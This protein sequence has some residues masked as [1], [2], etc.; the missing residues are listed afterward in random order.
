MKLKLD[1]ERMSDDFFEDTRILGIACPLKNYQFCWHVEKTLNIPFA[2]SLDLQIGMEK[3]KRSYSFTVY[4]FIHPI[5][6][7]EHFLYSNK[8]EGEFLLPEL[9][10]LDFIWLIRDPY[11]DLVELNDL[12][13]RLRT[14]PGVQLVTEVPH[15]K[16][17]SRDNLQR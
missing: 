4:V 13:Q 15:E 11:N 6:S 17:K 14:I 8:H 12:M 2:T 7:K 10:H 9:Q 1:D 3:N 5:T 16:I